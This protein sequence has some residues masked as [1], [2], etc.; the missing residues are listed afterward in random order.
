LSSTVELRNEVFL[1][2][3][4]LAARRGQSVQKIRKD[5][6]TGK[7]CPWRR[8]GRSVRYALSDILAEEAGS[9]YSSTSQYNRD[10][11][12]DTAGDGSSGHV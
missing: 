6:A 10:V 8:F 4:Q 7:G 9:K 3:R 5:R 11:A 2:E 12:T 1:N